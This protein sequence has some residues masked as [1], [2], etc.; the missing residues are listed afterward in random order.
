MKI[1]LWQAKRDFLNDT[2]YLLY[3]YLARLAEGCSFPSLCDISGGIPA[4]GEGEKF[5]NACLK[6]EMEC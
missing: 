1:I 5:G 2:Y 3:L 6:K 4:N